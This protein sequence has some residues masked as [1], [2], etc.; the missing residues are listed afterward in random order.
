MSD[1][2]LPPGATNRDIDGPKEAQ[3]GYDAYADGLDPEDNPY[4]YGTVEHDEWSGAWYYAEELDE[5][6]YEDA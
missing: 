1:P 3:E 5:E 2:Y 4:D 6:G